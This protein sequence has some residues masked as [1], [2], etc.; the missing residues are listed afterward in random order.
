M[1]RYSNYQVK[2]ISNYSYKGG[3][4]EAFI[5]QTNYFNQKGLNTTFYGPHDWFL[6]KCQGQLLSKLELQ[7]SDIIISHN[8][9]ADQKIPCRLHVLSCHEKHMFP[10]QN[11]NQRLWDK[12]HFVSEQQK[13]WH[14][15][16]TAPSEVIPN[17]LPDLLPNSKASK[18]VAAVIG[19]IDPN[20]QTHLSIHRALEKGYEKVLLFHGNIVQAYY[21]KMVAPLVDGKKVVLMGFWDDKQS[22]YDQVNCVFHSS[23]SECASYVEDE[24]YLTKTNIDILESAKSNADRWN[25]D[26][27]FDAWLRFLEIE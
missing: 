17:F 8:F 15:A 3:S 26:Q 14:G 20:K 23:L 25:M 27:I 5:L 1:E 7:E 19:S 22:M 13:N 24:C 12:I 16:I 11:H 10:I 21:D 18:N 9:Q 6:D 2:I 4:T